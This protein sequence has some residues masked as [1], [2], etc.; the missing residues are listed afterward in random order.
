MSKISQK[1]YDKLIDAFAQQLWFLR[2]RWEGI[3]ALRDVN[4]RFT[5]T[6][7]KYHRFMNSTYRSFV[8]DFYVGI[9]RLVVD[10]TKGVESMIRLLKKPPENKSVMTDKKRDKLINKIKNNTT[11]KKIKNQRD[12]LLA[13]QNS[14]LLFDEEFISQFRKLNNPSPDE[15]ELLMNILDDILTQ[16]ACLASFY[17][18]TTPDTP[19][20]REIEEVFSILDKE[21]SPVTTPI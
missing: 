17:P 6:W 21:F 5:S 3:K 1:D 15:I 16:M 13:H 7:S 12:F 14:N 4:K 20:K 9:C 18:K 2:E 10:D 19:I 8:Y 11:I